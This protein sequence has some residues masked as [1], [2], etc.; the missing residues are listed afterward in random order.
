MEWPGAARNVTSHRVIGVA[1]F[2]PAVSGT[3][4]IEIGVNGQC[5]FKVNALTL[6]SICGKCHLLALIFTHGIICRVLH[7]LIWIVIS[8]RLLISFSVL[9]FSPLYYVLVEVE[10]SSS[11]SVGGET[12]QPA[13]FKS[14][15][16]YTFNL[17][18]LG[19]RSALP[20][21]Q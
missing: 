18:L 17:Y 21:V 16:S 6:P 5:L 15:N 8:L 1:Q 10:L 2:S 11:G 3:V 12:Q 4:Q 20:V 13:A 7:W 14:I 9:R 19:S